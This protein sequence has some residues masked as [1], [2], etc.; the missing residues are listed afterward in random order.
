MT[1]ST[2]IRSK[3]RLKRFVHRIVRVTASVY[4]VL[5]LIL[6]GCQDWLVFPGASDQGKPESHIQY[7]GDAQ[8]LHLTTTNGIPIAAV[9]GSTGKPGSLTIL[10]FY[11]NAGAVAWSEGEFDHLRKMGCNVLIPDLA[12]YGDSGGKP[13]ETNFYATA[14][15]AWNYLQ[16]RPDIDHK[17]IIVVGWSLGAA[18]AIDLASRKP[19]AGLATFNAFTTLPAMARKLLPWFPTRLL[20]KYKFDN[21]TKIAQVHC[22]IFIC[23]GALDTL[24]PPAMSDQLTASAGGPVTRVIIPSADHNS[25]FVADPDQV[26]GAIEKWLKKGGKDI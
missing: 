17:K 20:L 18:V 10:Y 19:V 7:G 25:I 26:W 1:D 4:L 9:Y 22:P 8:T 14:D 3:A 6:S 23:N 5:C 12:G 13:S 16:S 11:G 2:N 24:V 15:A 21:Q